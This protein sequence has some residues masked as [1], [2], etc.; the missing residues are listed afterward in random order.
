MPSGNSELLSLEP[1]TPRQ[2]TIQ[3]HVLEKSADRLAAFS[4]STGEDKI[5][6]QSGD[7]GSGCSKNSA[8]LFAAPS[9]VLC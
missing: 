4:G 5:T 6:P 7:S 9:K 2:R 3:V 1:E 8:D